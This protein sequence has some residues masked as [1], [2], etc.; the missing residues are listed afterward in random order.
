M[1]YPILRVP[2]EQVPGPLRLY[3]IVHFAED[4]HNLA[5]TLLPVAF[6]FLRRAVSTRTPAAIVAAIVSSGCV[7]LANAFGA[8]GLAIGGVAVV[9]AFGGGLPVRL[10]I[11]FAA[12]LWV[13]PCGSP[14]GCHRHSST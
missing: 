2:F 4:P 10:A 13:S 5:L 14:H 11:G 6:L 7:V 8:I 9:L 3:N 1:V 12:Y